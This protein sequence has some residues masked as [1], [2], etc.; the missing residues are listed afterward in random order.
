[1]ATSDE[2]KYICLD[3]HYSTTRNVTQVRPGGICQLDP[4]SSRKGAGGLR[5]RGYFKVL[6]PDRPLLS[7]ITISLNSESGI[8][9][10]IQSVINQDYDNVEYIIVDG[11]SVDG[12]VEILKKYDSYLDYWVSESDKGIADG[13]NK[14]ISLASG[15]WIN[16][17]NAGDYFLSRDVIRYVVSAV[18]DSDGRYSFISGFAINGKLRMPPWPLSNSMHVFKKSLLSH[19]GTFFRRRVF[20]KYGFFDGQYKLRMDYDFFVKVLSVDEFKF[21]KTDICFYDLKGQSSLRLL[22]GAWEG[23]KI[24]SKHA[25]NIVVFL[26]R[27]LVFLLYFTNALLQMNSSIDKWR[28]KSLRLLKKAIWPLV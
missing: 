15:E 6:C 20:Y 8:E 14:G 21:I 17:M 2:I 28:R 1:M 24:E 7:I 26:W 5:K 13:F 23:L 9:R 3:K 22:E 16:F 12:T 25:N 11:G 4:N 18:L 10:T 27:I 19:Q